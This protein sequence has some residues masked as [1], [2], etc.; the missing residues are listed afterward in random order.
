M[1][2][3]AALALLVAAVTGIL[4]LTGGKSTTGNVA[5]NAPAVGP[6]VIHDDEL[7]DGDGRPFFL[8][9][10]DRP[11]LEWSCAG[12]SLG[13]GPGIPAS[14]FSAIRAWGAN[15]VRIPLNQDYWLSA[16]GVPVASS[17]HCPGYINTVKAV[18]REAEAQHLV[19]LLDLH[20]SDP[21]NPELKGG[22]EPMPDRGSI[23]F[24]RSVAGTFGGNWNVMFELFNEPHGV[25]WAVWQ[26]GGPV[27]SGPYSYQAVGMQ[28]LVDVVRGT[29]AHNVI[30]VDG[31][32]F[33]ATLAGVRSH[34]LTGG[35]IGYAVHPYTGIDTTSPG[36]WERR[37]G[38]LTSTNLVVATE[39][40]DQRPGVTGYDRNILNFFR[41]HAMGWTA[42]AW[43]DG[44][45]KFPS[46][47]DGRGA[48][49]DAG[50]PDRDALL[51]F[52][53]D[54]SRMVVPHSVISER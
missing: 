53:H 50:C 49:V 39:F 17:A 43:W 26:H 21:G 27:K 45:Y 51:A 42:W 13:G 6:Y 38:F 16:L 30:L 34:L 36:V 4:T 46:L 37:F 8:H 28:R 41:T 33:A 52:A 12:Q 10:V 15:T 44:T 7:L 1:V 14:D 29:G 20:S 25:S 11:S 18:V 32:N 19:V 23:R 31:I 54:R 24:W 35:G 3:A 40:G 47:I 2:V 5:A 48:C 22:P 9:G